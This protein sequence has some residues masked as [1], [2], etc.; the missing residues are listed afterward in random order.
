MIE[1]V[2]EGTVAAPQ[3][4]VWGLVSSPAEAGEW[5]AFADS[6]EVLSGDGVGQLRRQHGR[7]GGKRAEVDQELTA[8]AAPELIAW[9]H[10]AER[11]NGKPAPRFA[12]RTEFRIRLAPDGPGTR[13]RLDYQAEPAGILRGLAMKLF[14]TR[15]VAQL[16]E[17]SLQRLAARAGRR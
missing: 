17:Q 3:Q 5:F 9:R 6:V 12:R 8:F 2:R 15:E 1:I 14:G 16:M 13:V 11:L 4:V 10:V 7:W